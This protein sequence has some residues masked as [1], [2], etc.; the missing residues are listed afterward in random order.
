VNF[1]DKE[2]VDFEVKWV[3]MAT[4]EEDEFIIKAKDP[5]A[6]MDMQNETYFQNLPDYPSAR[7]NFMEQQQE[8]IRMETEK[9]KESTVTSLLNVWNYFILSAHYQK[10]VGF[11]LPSQDN[12]IVIYY[13]GCFQTELRKI[14]LCVP[15]TIAYQKLKSTLIDKLPYFFGGADNAPTTFKWMSEAR[16]YNED[17]KRQIHELKEMYGI[18]VG[19]RERTEKNANDY[20]YRCIQ[21]ELAKLSAAKQTEIMSRIE[22]QESNW[23][24]EN[25]GDEYDDEDFLRLC[26]EADA[27][28]AKKKANIAEEEY[29]RV[30]TTCQTLLGVRTHS[31]VEG[32]VGPGGSKRPKLNIHLRK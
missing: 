18:C 23:R 14:Q 3:K 2:S 5:L 10:A 25:N 6:L 4:T 8:T 13:D 21:Q 17:G 28:Y 29:R 19:L 16:Y 30:N 22:A 27:M 12:S 9:E 26:N 7:G 20:E 24:L 11:F 1:V 32:A 15:L 31:E